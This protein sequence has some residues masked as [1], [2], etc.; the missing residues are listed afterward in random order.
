MYQV[1]YHTAA[2][3]GWISIGCAGTAELR[4][5]APEGVAVT[6]HAALVKE[7]AKT[8]ER[9][10]FSMT[11]A[12]KSSNKSQPDKKPEPSD[13]DDDEEEDAEHS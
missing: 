5:W 3:F 10:G 2:G 12:L 8:F 7:Y 9:P 11:M 6:K 1:F 4:V 13:E